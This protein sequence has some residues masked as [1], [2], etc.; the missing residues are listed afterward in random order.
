[1]YYVYHE[2]NDIFHYKK[3]FILFLQSDSGGPLIVNGKLVGLVSWSK[4]CSLTDFPTVYTRVPS[5]VNWIRKH[6]V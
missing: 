1:M 3:I 6:A 2:L 5:H 4:G